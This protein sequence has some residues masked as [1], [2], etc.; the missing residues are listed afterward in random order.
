M[1]TLFP[2]LVF[3]KTCSQVLTLVNEKLTGAGFRIVQ[4]FNLQTARLAHLECQ[5]P[6]H[7]T[8]DCNCQMVI[9]LVYGKQEDPATLIIHSQDEKTGVS[10]SGPAGDHAT[11]NL[12][13]TIRRVL[14]SQISHTF[15]PPEVSHEPRVAL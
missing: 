11:Q 14:V 2:F 5:C 3:E 4:T 12:G 13:S 10:L 7:G 15:T 1:S 6:H 8:S 9:L